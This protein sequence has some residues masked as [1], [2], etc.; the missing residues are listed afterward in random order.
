MLPGIRQFDLTGRAALVKR[1]FDFGF[2]IFDFG[3]SFVGDR[4]SV[5]VFVDQPSTIN[6]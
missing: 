4:M 2:P 3:L 6:D 5:G 1:I